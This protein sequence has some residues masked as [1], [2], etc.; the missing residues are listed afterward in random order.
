MRFLLKA[1][2]PVHAANV[3]AKEG[4][5]GETIEK[6][7][8]DLKPEACYFLAEDG[9]RTAFIFLNMDDPSQI[10][11]LAEPWFLAFDAQVRE[12][13]ADG[14]ASIEAGLLR[15]EEINQQQDIQVLLT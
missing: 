2:M 9:Q 14:A 11:A 12:V 7:C 15:T 6:I 8:A 13:E 1:T 10:P 5:L 4:K 3:R